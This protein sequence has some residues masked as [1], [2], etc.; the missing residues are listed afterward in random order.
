VTAKWREL[1]DI[2]LS[3]LLAV[4]CAGLIGWSPPAVAQDYGDDDNQI[5]AEENL[6]PPAGYPVPGA[7]PAP[8]AQPGAPAQEQVKDSTINLIAD[9]VGHDETLGIFVARGNVEILREG[10]IVKADVITYNERT[11][12][13][14]A[15]G[16][17]VLL[18]PD[19]D[20]QFATYADVTDDVKE[21]I[22]YDFRMLM[23]DHA[24]L[25]ANRAYR[26]EQ[27]TK[28]IL[29]K[30]VYTPCAPCAEDPSRSPLWQVKAYSA[31][32]D[33]VKKTITYHDAW[34]EMFG[35]PVLYTPWFRHPDFDVDRQS[36]MLTPELHYS[37]ENGLQISTP[38]YHVLGPDKD[39]TFTPIFRFGGDLQEH[40]GGVID[41]EYRQ[42]V[43]DGRF[44]LE[45]SGT[46]EDR[47]SDD[48][49]AEDRHE[50]T[51]DFRGHIEGDGL[52]DINDDWRTGFDFKATTDKKYLKR[53]HLGSRD[54]L[55]DTAYVE[56]FFGRS[57]TEA[58]GLAF[59][60]TDED[61]QTDQLPIIAPILDYRFVGEPGIAGAYWGLD[62]NFM[63]L[64]RV[65]GREEVRFAANPYWT[66]PYTSSMGDIYRLTLEVPMTAQIVHDV[67]PDSNDVDPTHDTFSGT[68][69]TAVPKASFDWSYPFIRPSPTFTQVFEPL[70]QLVVAPDAGNKG[71]IPNEDSRAFELDDTNVLLADR[72]PG[73]NRPDTGSRASYGAQWSAYLPQGSYINAFLGQSFQFTHDDTDE[74]RSGTG[75]DDDLTNMVGRLQFRP[76]PGIDLSYR[77]RFDVEET[78][79][80]RHEV[81]ATYSNPYF[82]FSSSYAF[83][84]SDGVEFQD[85]EQV[86][87]YLGTSLS[88]YWSVNTRSSYDLNNNR[89]LS[90]GGGLR[91]LDEC[92]DM[93][94]DAAYVP[95]GETEESEGDVNVLFTITFR[96]LGGLDIPY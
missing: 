8:G 44:R 23:K 14:T 96:N 18:E 6:P 29:R 83:I 50:I 77:F 45:G 24:R 51:N 30:G 64:R 34:L 71:R 73:L 69:F 10:T 25:A 21:G 95:S 81:R 72:F 76:M 43:V 56:G 57:Y 70:F 42:R 16:N 11:K 88:D 9:E 61:V 93:S 49:R 46:V 40:P 84:E 59:Q 38:Y 27:D 55:T 26:V 37:S 22:L 82:A 28:E 78:T 85:R 17:V 92:F 35:V 3:G 13:I 15:A 32:R 52:F 20:T 80:K 65:D 31:I 60:S 75:I 62:T 67:N 5:R 4:L 7:Q 63:N 94:F 48:A 12:R 19:G 33:K 39:I 87:A 58:R 54:I 53:F 66:L 36:G 1:S 47:E 68:V 86:S 89:L 74:F 2:V 90:V 41:L 91:Y 79:F